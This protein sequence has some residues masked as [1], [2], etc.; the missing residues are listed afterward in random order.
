MKRLLTILLV[1]TSY[2][3]YGQSVYYVATDGNDGTGDGSVGNSWAT[4]TYAMSASSPVTAGDSI[5]VK[6]GDYGNEQVVFAKSG[7]SGNR[8]VIQGYKTTPGDQPKSDWTYGDSHLSSEMPYFDYGNREAEVISFDFNEQEYITVNNMQVTEYQFAVWM[9][10]GHNII[11]NFFCTTLGS[12][13]VEGRS[14]GIHL[15][16]NKKSI[17]GVDYGYDADSSKVINCTVINSAGEGIWVWSDYDTIQDCEIYC[18]DECTVGSPCPGGTDYYIPITGCHNYIVDCYA[19]RVSDA[20]E[21]S[22]HGIGVKGTWLGTGYGGYYHNYTEYNTVKRCTIRN[23]GNE[24]FWVAHPNVRYNIFD[25]CYAVQGDDA[26][27]VRDSAH[28]NTFRYC[29]ADSINDGH[30]VVIDLKDGGESLDGYS[31]VNNTFHNI[32]I[33]N[34]EKVL[35]IRLGSDDEEP[36]NTWD[37]LCNNNKFW[38]ITVYNCDY[39]IAYVN[40]TNADNEFKNWIVHTMND[41]AYSWTKTANFEFYYSD[42]YDCSSWDWMDDYTDDPSNITDNPLFTNIEESDL[43]LQETSPCI[44]EGTDVGL[45]YNGTAPDMGAYEY[46]AT[47]GAAI[48]LTKT[49]TFNDEDSDGYADVD[50]TIS[51][52]FT[53]ENT[54]S[55]ELTN[56]DISDPGLTVS[57]GPTTLSVD[58]T[59]NTTFSATYTITQTDIDAGKFDNTA[60]VTCDEAVEDSDSESVTLHEEGEIPPP[61]Y[62]YEYVNTG[63]NDV[64]NYDHIN[65]WRGQTFTVGTVGTNESFQILSVRLLCYKTGSP[66]NVTVSIRAVDTDGWTPTGDILSTGTILSADLNTSESWQTAYMSDYLLEKNTTY[67]IQVTVASADESNMFHWMNNTNNPYAG[68]SA[69]Y[70]NNGGTDW[71]RTLANDKLFE[72]WGLAKYIGKHNGNIVTHNGIMVTISE[73]DIPQTPKSDLLEGPSYNNVEVIYGATTFEEYSVGFLP[74]DSLYKALLNGG[75]DTVTRHSGAYSSFADADAKPHIKYYYFDNEGI[76]DSS[77]GV[78]FA[79]MEGIGNFPCEVD[80]PFYIPINARIVFAERYNN[81]EDAYIDMR[82][83]YDVYFEP[84]SGWDNSDDSDVWKLNGIY[85]GSAPTADNNAATSATPGNWDYSV[86]VQNNAVGKGHSTLSKYR[87][88]GYPTSE[89]FGSAGYCTNILQDPSDTSE[90]YFSSFADEEVHTITL[91]LVIKDTGDYNNGF[92]EYFIDGW[93]ADICHFWDINLYDAQSMWL[94]SSPDA[95][96]IKCIDDTVTAQ[97]NAFRVR[98]HWG[99]GC[100]ESPTGSDAAV[101]F[102]NFIIDRDTVNYVREPWPWDVRLPLHSSLNG[103]KKEFN[104]YWLLFLIPT[105]RRKRY[106]NSKA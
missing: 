57:G 95:V 53:V 49:G 60:T 104:W 45:D 23:T 84:S 56:V 73:D 51:Y 38:N 34:S 47:S 25:S 63:A 9:D 3:L 74:E 41:D 37:A 82:Q 86:G 36:P 105:L 99:G 81:S 16:G 39:F 19:E 17:Y 92:Y 52:T 40:S 31:S 66:G 29:K 43:T 24:A 102:D 72:V 75:A 61:G 101:V 79:M 83:H 35:G 88:S 58:E 69:I 44:D 18:D 91:R 70:S 21:H 46:E 2:C 59:D 14:S 65:D 1:I 27:V 98:Y 48:S 7:T 85:S 4:I 96:P 50:E 26:F 12:Q 28:L 103:W 15:R 90:V 42:F 55:V 94:E 13:S 62:L 71:N 33:S 64:S 8:I 100:D 30:G 6:A 80:D 11:E 76:T 89:M 93:K 5:Y 54:G 87:F 68:G 10:G 20:V 77:K 97:I 22:G 67:A 106:G 32:T 78:R